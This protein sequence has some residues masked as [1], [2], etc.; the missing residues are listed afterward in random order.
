MAYIYRLDNNI[1]GMWYVGSRSADPKNDCDYL[2]SS[3]TIKAAVKK[4]GKSNF[5]KTILLECSEYL[6]YQIESKYLNALDA[7]NCP[8]SYNKI[9]YGS[10]LQKG[11]K[12]SDETKKK[13]SIATKKELN[14]FYGKIHTI[15]SKQKMSEAR[16]GTTLSDSTKQKMSISRSGC[17]NHQYG[18]PLSDAQKKKMSDTVKNKFK[19]PLNNPNTNKTIY[20][21][22]HKEHGDFIGMRFELIKKYSLNSSHLSKVIKGKLSHTK[23]WKLAVDGQ[24]I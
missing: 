1:N 9:N 8:S 2:G 4:Y 21:F 14:P 20:H 19:N 16:K 6:K 24:K 23:G 5:T 13:I 11:F 22:T 15:E 7:K 3:K 10:G 12:L 18:K 17:K